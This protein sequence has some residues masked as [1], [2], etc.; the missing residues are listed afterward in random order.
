MIS[1]AGCNTIAH[2]EMIKR[3]SLQEIM[4]ISSIWTVE[5]RRKDNNA[6]LQR[7]I[8]KNIY[9]IEGAKSILDVAVHGATQISTWYVVPFNS[10]TTPIN[11]MIYATPVFTEFTGYSEA[12]R[13][14]YSEAA[15]ANSSNTI[16]MTNSA[17]KA[18]FTITGSDTIY[19]AAIVGGGSAPGTKSDTAGGGTLLCVT[20]FAA[21]IAV[22]ATTVLS[23][24]V[25][26]NLTI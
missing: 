26:I 6:L 8:S 16:Y 23:T 9:T 4:H 5:L 15:A 10:N 2:V 18:A 1:N 21:G 19:G 22:D 11:T 14:I 7:S 24:T 3:P 12:T 13:Q 25:Q 17:N 20:K